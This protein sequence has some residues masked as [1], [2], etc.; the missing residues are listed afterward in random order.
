MAAAPNARV[1]EIEAAIA[2]GDESRIR[3]Y[4]RDAVEH[5]LHDRDELHRR[6]MLIGRSCAETTDTFAFFALLSVLLDDRK[7]WD[8]AAKQLGQDFDPGFEFL[9][10]RTRAHH[11]KNHALENW[12]FLLSNARNKGHVPAAILY[13]RRRFGGRSLARYVLLPPIL[14]VFGL[15]AAVIAM[16]DRADRRLATY[17]GD[18]APSG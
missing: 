15:K 8:I 17:T 2:G 16:S 5:H 7:G 3:D 18:R 9:A 4:Y 11:F 13:W 10:Y 14:A 12:T 6:R 1:R